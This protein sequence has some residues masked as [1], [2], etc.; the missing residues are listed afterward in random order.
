MEFY[1]S[2][3]AFMF[4]LGW[5]TIQ[6]GCSNN[7]F[8]GASK[9]TRPPQAT[10]TDDLTPYTPFPTPTPTVDLQTGTVVTK[11]GVNLDDHGGDMDFNDT[12]YCFTFDG[13]LKRNPKR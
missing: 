11:V 5:L 9:I 12:V 8:S 6:Y 4:F 1:R 10:Q 2:Q 7:N 3:I 13:L